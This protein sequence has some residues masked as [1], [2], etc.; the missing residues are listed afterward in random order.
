MEIGGGPVAGFGCALVMRS[1]RYGVAHPYRR[2]FL[3]LYGR[4]LRHLRS[5]YC[6]PG[7]PLVCCRDLRC[8]SLLRNLVDPALVAS[9]ASGVGT[10][11][12]HGGVVA[13]NW[14][15]WP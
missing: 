10:W 8:G 7:E 15:K 12:E 13:L 2:D 3:V 5:R 1:P 6:D 9:E 4:S 11:G 14:R